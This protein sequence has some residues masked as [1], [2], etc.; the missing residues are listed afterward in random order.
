LASLNVGCLNVECNLVVRDTGQKE[1]V[2]AG[3]AENPHVQGVDGKHVSV[4]VERDG[5]TWGVEHR[6]GVLRGPENEC[7]R[8]E[9]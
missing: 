6:R 9:R 1:G 8:S 4:S 7:G 3:T 5:A 2:L